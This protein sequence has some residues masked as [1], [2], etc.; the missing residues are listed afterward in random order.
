MV[1]LDISK[2][3]IKEIKLKIEYGRKWIQLVIYENLLVQCGIC[4]SY[5]HYAKNC[6]EKKRRNEER[7]EKEKN[8]KDS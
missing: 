3:M 6:L 1:N 5:V 4:K 8:G 7:R 2:P